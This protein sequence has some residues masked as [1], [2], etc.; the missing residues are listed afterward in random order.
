VA[1]LALAA[2]QRA[3][4]H[5]LVGSVTASALLATLPL[6]LLRGWPALHDHVA[7]ALVRRGGRRR[8][9]LLLGWSQGALVLLSL[10]V[11]L[12]LL[13]GLGLL[14]VSPGVLAIAGVLTLAARQ[15]HLAAL[16]LTLPGL[17]QR[18]TQHGTPLPS[19]L[20]CPDCGGS[21]R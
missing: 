13:G 3:L 14:P 11:G 9:T 8:A 20:V 6:V 21:R 4:R 5:P 1:L 17:L 12:A 2:A 10:E 19:R 7:S 16:C 15:G 18:A